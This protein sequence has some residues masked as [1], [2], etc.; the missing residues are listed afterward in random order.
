MENKDCTGRRIWK[1]IGFGE[2]TVVGRVREGKQSCWLSF[3]IMCTNMVV[4]NTRMSVFWHL[5]ITLVYFRLWFIYFITFSSPQRISSLD[6]STRSVISLFNNLL[7]SDFISNFFCWVY[8]FYKFL[9]L[10]TCFI[11][12]LIVWRFLNC[13]LRLNTDF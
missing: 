9:E 6:L 7:I 1:S 11:H 5:K 12:S 3:E 8:F 2:V 13:N 10:D 4:E